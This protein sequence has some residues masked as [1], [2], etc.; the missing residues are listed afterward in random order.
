MDWQAKYLTT[1]TEAHPAETI[2]ITALP[3]RSRDYTETL[4]ALVSSVA[5]WWADRL[6]ISI[7]AD[8]SGNSMH[9]HNAARNGS[10]A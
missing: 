6:V 7:K 2:K 8:T 10:M 3:R 1:S 5:N 9:Q 4:G